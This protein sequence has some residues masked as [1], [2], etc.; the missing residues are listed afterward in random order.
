MVTFLLLNVIKGEFYMKKKRLLRFVSLVMCFVLVNSM[1]AFAETGE[2]I[3]NDTCQ[4]IVVN[5]IDEYL[6][7]LN[8]GIIV[9]QNTTI[10]TFESSNE[11]IG[12]RSW[13]WTDCSNILGHD[14][15]SWSA[16]EETGE[17]VHYY[18]SLCIAHIRRIRFCQR[19][20]CNAYEVEEDVMWIQCPH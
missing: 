15:G 12:T 10:T 20:H 17:R 1:V 13:P 8:E 14:W 5:D 6:A 18:T 11:S 7:Q 3:H 4:H 2:H 9:P 16:W 19:T